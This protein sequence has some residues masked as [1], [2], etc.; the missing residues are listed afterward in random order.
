MPVVNRSFMPVALA[1]AFMIRLAL[2]FLSRI[3]SIG[4]C[5]IEDKIVEKE[6]SVQTESSFSLSFIL[7]FRLAFSHLLLIFIRVSLPSES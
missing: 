1:V 4:V 6:F 2:K 7:F 5:S 3:L